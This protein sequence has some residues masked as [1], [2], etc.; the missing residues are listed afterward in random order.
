MRS[1]NPDSGSFV[2]DNHLLSGATA[3]VDSVVLGK[4]H[5]RR[6]LSRRISKLSVSTTSL[7]IE[8]PETPPYLPVKANQRELSNSVTNLNIK[9]CGCKEADFQ[10]NRNKR[11]LKNSRF[12]NP[13]ELFLNFRRAKLLT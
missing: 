7:E 4:E 5:R 1:K 11:K 8:L 10:L 6:R 2:P 13:R 12:P 9:D 3:T